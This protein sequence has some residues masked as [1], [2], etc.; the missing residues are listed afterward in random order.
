MK[1]DS[2]RALLTEE[3]RDIYDA[4]KQI[5]RALPKMIKNTQSEELKLALTEHL[6]E[7]KG[8]IQRLERCFDLLEMKHRSKPCSGMKGLLE[9]GQEVMTEVTEEPYRDAAIISA[10]QRVEHYEIAAY[11]TVQAYAEAIGEEDVAELLRET[12]EEE[13]TADKKLTEIGV[14]MFSEMELETT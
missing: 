6:E 9:E 1:I 14:E 13:K 3:L 10:A 7:T 11:G 5:T 8:Q 4:E 2:L 12:L